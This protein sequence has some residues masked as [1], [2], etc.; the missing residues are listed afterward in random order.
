V[1]AHLANGNSAKVTQQDYTELQMYFCRLLIRLQPQPWFNY[2]VI[3]ND[4]DLAAW[5]ACDHAPI[6]ARNRVMDKCDDL[7]ATLSE[8]LQALRDRYTVVNRILRG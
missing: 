6:D 1:L 7:Y 3:L 5:F 4:P 8:D 2:G